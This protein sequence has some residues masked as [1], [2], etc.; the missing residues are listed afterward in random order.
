MPRPARVD[1]ER[2][3]LIYERL[4]LRATAR[5]VGCTHPYLS[6]RLK[7]FELVTRKQGVVTNDSGKEKT[8]CKSLTRH[9]LRLV[10]AKLLPPTTE[11]VQQ[12]ILV[13]GAIARGFVTRSD[14]CQAMAG[15]LAET[16]VWNTLRRCV[17]RGDLVEERGETPVGGGIPPIVYVIP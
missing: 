10:K 12:E 2:A 13:L 8:P 14:V 7:K 4:G 16:T 9:D 6:R 1:L 17:E 15:V 5:I 11:R 3:A